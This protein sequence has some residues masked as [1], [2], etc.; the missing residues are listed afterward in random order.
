MKWGGPTWT[1]FHTL[2]EKV[3]PEQFPHIRN[4]LVGIIVLI[5]TNLPCPNCSAHAVQYLKQFNMN[6]I[7]TQAQL[8]YFLYEF[9]NSVN[10]RKSVP[11]YDFNDL[12]WYSTTN[13]TTVMHTFMYHFEGRYSRQAAMAPQGFAR[14]NITKKL[15]HWFNKYHDAFY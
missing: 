8:K 13:T 15:K 2:A 14:A 3:K 7:Q 4:E 5:A 12:A 11:A 1:L 10:A 9:H 6:A